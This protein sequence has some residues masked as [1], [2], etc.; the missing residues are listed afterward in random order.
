MKKRIALT[1]SFAALAAFACS[2]SRD[3][4]RSVDNLPTEI[5]TDDSSTEISDAGAP[6]SKK[7]STTDSTP[8][9]VHE[10]G[11]AVAKIVINEVSGSGEWLEIMNAGTEAVDLTGFAITDRDQDDGGPNLD[12]TVTFPKGL[13]LSPNAYVI[14]VGLDTGT[15][16]D[17]GLCPTGGWSYC[18]FGEFGISD[19]KGETMYLLDAERGI[20]ADVAYPANTVTEPDTWGRIPN[21]TGSFKVTSPTPGGANKAK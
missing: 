14:V 8:V 18:L 21:G 19:K 20:I 1:L 5:G 12:H 11:G 3:T 10:A 6:K 2:E 17:A 4:S 15:P 9:E 7:D 13:I 16:P